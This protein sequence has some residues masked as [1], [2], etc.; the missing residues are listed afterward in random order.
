M[1]DQPTWRQ[2][3]DDA[4]KLL[5]PGA[6]KFRG[7]QE[8]AKLGNEGDPRITDWASEIHATYER[9]LLRIPEDHPVCVA[10]LDAR[11]RL[12]AFAEALEAESTGDAEVDEFETARSAFLKAARDYLRQLSSLG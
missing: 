8:A 4:A 2:L 6:T 11:T 9:M 10:Y 7:A 5:A 3:L 12:V 1:I